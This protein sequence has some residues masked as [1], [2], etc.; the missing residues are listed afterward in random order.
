MQQE[1]SA[2]PDGLAFWFSTV[3][4]SSGYT[5]SVS[6]FFSCN[7]TFNSLMPTTDSGLKSIN[8]LNT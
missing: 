6:L 5:S 4:F 3:V 2:E 1:Q 7:Y 8:C